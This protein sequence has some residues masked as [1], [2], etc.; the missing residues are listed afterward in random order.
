MGNNNSTAFG[1]ALGAPRLGFEYRLIA[2]LN[3]FSH[4]GPYLRLGFDG[5]VHEEA[6]LRS[7]YDQKIFTLRDG[8]ITITSFNGDQLCLGPIPSPKVPW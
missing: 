8:H 4:G 1:D 5:G 3:D 7:G 2:S 6:L